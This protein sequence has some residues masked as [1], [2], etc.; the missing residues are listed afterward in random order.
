M[1]PKNKKKA[2]KYAPVVVFA[3][4]RPQHTLKTLESLS[5]NTLA[6]KTDLYIFCDGPKRN[7]SP[8]DKEKIKEVKRL[9]K[10]KKWCKRVIVQEE[11]TNKGLAKS[12][13]DGVTKVVNKYGRIIVLED[14]LIT[15]AGFLLYM[16]VAL[17]TYSRDNGVMH[18][19]AYQYPIKHKLP[20]TFFLSHTS[21]WGWATWKDSWA[22]LSTNPRQLLKKIIT[23]G[24][25][26]EFD[27][28]GAYPYSQQ[29]EMNIT[30]Q[31][32][33]WAIMWLAS[34]FNNNGLVLYPGK[35]L[36]KNVGLDNTGVHSGDDTTYS[37]KDTAKSINVKRIEKKV[38][39]DCASK[40]REFF[41][42][43]DKQLSKKYSQK[44][45]FFKITSRMRGY[46]LAK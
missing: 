25:L 26:N 3:Y 31:L 28:D 39:N 1:S 46:F 8:E 7:A 45:L 14:D 5:L 16:N 43:R 29:L 2:T 10:C 27:L 18:I 40:V 30:G 19:S 44:K 9:V 21:S 37:V 20:E 15:S 35:S 11:D 36:V 38:S 34:V 33:T 17:D 22:K 6:N 32:N 23:T 12:I 13:I 41:L 42:W 24:R 4:N